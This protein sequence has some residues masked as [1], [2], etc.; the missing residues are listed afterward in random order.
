MNVESTMPNKNIVTA[1]E[2]LIRDYR[3]SLSY[4][5]DHGS[6][7]LYDNGAFKLVIF[8]WE[9]FDDLD[10]HLVYN[11]QDYKIDPSF[12]EP[13]SIFE[14]KLK[15]KGIRGLFYNFEKN[16]WEIVARI[17][18]RKLQQLGIVEQRRKGLGLS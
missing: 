11:L 18:K 13:K 10:I 7:Y 16:Y 5:F 3:C 4:E 6:R 17:I 12:E 9:E 1:L 15:R 2:F 8:H 14:I